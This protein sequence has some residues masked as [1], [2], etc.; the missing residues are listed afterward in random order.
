MICPSCQ[1]END[2]TTE[3]CFTCG[4]PLAALTLGSVIAS[5]YEIVKI[6]GKGGMGMVYQAFDRMLEEDVAIKVL[7]RDLTGTPEMAQRFRSEIKL[8]RKVSHPNVCRIHE[9]G[10]DA[11]ISFISMALLEGREVADLLEQ[12]PQG[13]PRDEA[14]E[15]SLQVARGLQAAHPLFCLPPP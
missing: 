5:R 3:V 9:S 11:G 7:R 10:E 8:A 13:L 2:P 14:F 12:N 6:L 4:K 1:A 15:V